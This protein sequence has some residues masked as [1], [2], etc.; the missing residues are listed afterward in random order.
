MTNHVFRN[1]CIDFGSLL[2]KPDVTTMLREAKKQSKTSEAK[3][4]MDARR[5]F[6]KTDITEDPTES[7]PAYFGAFGEWLCQHYLTYYG[8]EYNLHTVEMVDSEDSTE[9]DYGIDGRAKTTKTQSK[10]SRI[11]SM[12]GRK[13]QPGSLVFIQVKA[14]MNPTKEYSPNDGARI[15]NFFT[16]ALSEAIINGEAYQARYIIFTTGKGFHYSMDKMSHRM[17]E[18]IGIHEIK[19]FMDGDWAFLNYLR[20]QVAG[21]APL[22]IPS[23]QKDNEYTNNIESDMVDA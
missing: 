22:Q 11:V 14:S 18:V 20:S 15:P 16:Y 23:S 17:A 9:E 6:I 12:T 5:N 21:L 2:A 13:A 1:L 3:N 19:R 7:C 8:P 10:S 4:R